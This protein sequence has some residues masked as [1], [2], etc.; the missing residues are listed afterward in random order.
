VDKF[1]PLLHGRDKYGNVVTGTD[2][3]YDRQTMVEGM[4]LLSSTS[5]LNLCRFCH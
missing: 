1:R 2:R 5:Q 4:G 3:T